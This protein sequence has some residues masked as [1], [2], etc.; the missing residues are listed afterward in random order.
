MFDQSVQNAMWNAASEMQVTAMRQGSPHVLMRPRIFPDGTAWCALYGE[1]LQAGVAGFGDT[2]EAAC[3]DFDK[4]W[5][6]QK[7]PSKHKEQS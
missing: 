6:G 1:D 5:S 4:N 3:A 7:L 2:P